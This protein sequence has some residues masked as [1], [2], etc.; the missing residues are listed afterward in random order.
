MPRNLHKTLAALNVIMRYLVPIVADARL[1]ARIDAVLDQV[2]P[3]MR[4]KVQIA[5]WKRILRLPLDQRLVLLDA[6]VAKVLPRISKKQVPGKQNP[7]RE[8]CHSQSLPD[9]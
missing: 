8:R 1:T 7:G 5:L 9:P 3:E 6:V 2:S 4:P